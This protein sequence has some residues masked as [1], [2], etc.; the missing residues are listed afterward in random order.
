MIKP[1]KKLEDFDHPIFE[2]PTSSQTGRCIIGGYYID[3]L[4]IYVF[5]DLLGFIRAIKLINN[6]WLEVANTKLET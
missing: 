5:G 4:K 1:G 2:Y 3:K 6:Q